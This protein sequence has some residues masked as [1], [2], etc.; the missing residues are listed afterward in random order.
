MNG[1]HLS[2]VKVSVVE[3]GESFERH[4][5]AEG[6]GRGEVVGVDENGWGRN[7]SSACGRS[8]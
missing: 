4:G 2:I 5:A 3:N 8:S 6:G 1:I 7:Q